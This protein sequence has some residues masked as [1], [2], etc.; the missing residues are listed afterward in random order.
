LFN[1]DLKV[2]NKG[3]LKKGRHTWCLH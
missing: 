1:S 3:R 2:D